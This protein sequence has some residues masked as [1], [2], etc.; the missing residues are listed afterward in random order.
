VAPRGALVGFLNLW[1]SS[2]LVCGCDDSVLPSARADAVWSDA[3]EEASSFDASSSRG[4]PPIPVLDAGPQNSCNG[5]PLLCDRRY[6]TVAFLAT[7]QSAAAGPDWATPTQGRTLEEQFTI[8]GIRAFELE[9]HSIGGVLAVCV[10]SC[11][12]GNESLSRVLETIRTFLERNPTDVLTLLVRSNVRDDALGK[13]IDSS[14]LNGFT[15]TQDRGAPWPTLAEMIS[16]DRRLVVFVDRHTIRADAGGVDA[17]GK[18]ILLPESGPDA[19]TDAAPGSPLPPWLHPSGDWMWETSPS[20]GP[21]C[22]TAIGN[23]QNP[24]IVVNHYDQA[25]AQADASI[26]AAHEPDRIASR[27]RRC[28]EDRGRAVTLVVVDF[29]EIGDPNGGVQLENGV[30]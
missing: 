14:G 15:H 3:A 2:I 30:R 18:Q 9:V 16:S 11:A 28:R 19:V 12:G 26:A 20:V 5:S 8:G 25:D 1:L 13:A 24:L 4:G 22:V 10:G 21:D 7:H 29:A 17:A 6:D 23:P 27:L